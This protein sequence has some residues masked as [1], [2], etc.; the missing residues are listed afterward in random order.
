MYDISEGDCV[1]G[2]VCKGNGNCFMFP[3]NRVMLRKT[4]LFYIRNEQY[5]EENTSSTSRLSGTGSR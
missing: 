1:L 4:A 5:R 3:I 2:Y